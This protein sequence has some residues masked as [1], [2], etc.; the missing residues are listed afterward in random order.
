MT[1]PWQQPPGLREGRLR[2]RSADFPVRSNELPE[3]CYRAGRSAP[4]IC[5]CCGLESR[6][7]SPRSDANK[8]P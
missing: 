1:E 6:L 3:N 4:A 7:E 8:F 2:C 5:Q